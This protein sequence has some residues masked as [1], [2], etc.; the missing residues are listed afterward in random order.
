[1]AMQTI[2][3][4]FD[5]RETAERAVRELEAAGYS[6]T[7]VSLVAA[8]RP[9]EAAEDADDS[10]GAG[11]GAS[12][13]A[14][15]GG[16]AGLLAGIGSLAI[17]GIGPIVAAGWLVAAL[18]GAGAGAAAGGLLGALT[19]AGVSR[20]DAAVYSEG[21]R[22]GSV[23]VSVRVE[24]TRAAAAEAILRRHQPV[25][26]ETRRAEYRDSGWTGEADPPGS[27]AS[28][29]FDRVAGTNVSGAFPEQSDGTRDNPPGTAADRAARR[30]V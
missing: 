14:A 21:L 5:T 19:D 4:M 23:L 15:V 22:R 29:G 13:G 20:E 6:D 16:G 18:A 28:R 8:D 9:G 25:D 3:R 26:L 1:M 12:I 27:M 10:S 24:E 2:V 11:V 7:D 17:P 30:V